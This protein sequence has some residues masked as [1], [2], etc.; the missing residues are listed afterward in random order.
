MIHLWD[1]AEHFVKKAFTV[2]LASTIVVWALSHFSWSWNFLEDAQMN[3]S[4]LASVGQLL[5]PIFTPLGFGSQLG[6]WG[7]VFIVSAI[8]GLIAKEN[9]VSTFGVLAACITGA[10]IDIEADGGDVQAV[11][12]MINATGISVGGL[13]SFIVFN[14]TTIPCF[15]ATAAAKAELKQGTFKWTLLFWIVAS[16]VASILVYHVWEYPWT[17]AL[18]ASLLA[19]VIVAVVF[20]NKH[21]IQIVKK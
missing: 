20:Y 10:L 1:K 8:V 2:I 5:Q 9:V 4:I 13:L 17:I 16:F 21:K 3:Q 6:E 18:F 11:L 12:A 14:M 19:L 15:A 7:W